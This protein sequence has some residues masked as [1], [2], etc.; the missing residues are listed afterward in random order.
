MA[1]GI[2]V[3]EHLSD[4][5]QQGWVEEVGHDIPV[6]S[7][8]AEVTTEIDFDGITCLEDLPS[9]TGTMMQRQAVM[10]RLHQEQQGR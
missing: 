9:Q 1:S 2:G 4:D 5:L 10:K 7:S 6:E 8:A 3:A